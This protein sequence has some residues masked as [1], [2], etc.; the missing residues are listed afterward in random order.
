MLVKVPSRYHK[1]ESKSSLSC[2]NTHSAMLQRRKEWTFLVN[3]WLVLEIKWHIEREYTF[4]VS[5]SWI[6]FRCLRVSTLGSI[7]TRDATSE[8]NKHGSWKSCCILLNH[9]L[10]LYRSLF[11]GRWESG[12]R[13]EISIP[14]VSAC[15][16]N[17]IL[18]FAYNREVSAATRMTFFFWSFC[19][20]R[21]T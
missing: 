4:L 16:L 12:N 2:A 8:N 5:N 3:I 1:L 7:D 11:S 19:S 21:Q 18:Q 13:R 15:V 20:I 14:G 6:F 9:L 10:L 17:H